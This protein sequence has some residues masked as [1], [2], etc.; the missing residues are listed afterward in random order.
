MRGKAAHTSVPV[1]R[2]NKDKN[3]FVSDPVSNNITDASNAT[4]DRGVDSSRAVELKHVG[5]DVSKSLSNGVANGVTKPVVA[6]GV[7]KP[8]LNGVAK[9]AAANG[10]GPPNVYNFSKKQQS[11]LEAA[12][13]KFGTNLGVERWTKVSSAV[14]GKSAEECEARYKELVTYFKRAKTAN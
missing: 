9:P 14:P 1:A 5:N 4:I 2:P 7:T 3:E 8:V 12:M 11:A 10:G 6:N 13:K